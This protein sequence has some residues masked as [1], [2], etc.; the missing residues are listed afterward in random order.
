MIGAFVFVHAGA[1]PFFERGDYELVLVL[2]AAALLLAVL[3]AGRYSL[4]HQ[5]TG[6]RRTAQPVGA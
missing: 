4:D 6:R 3:G 1:G 5:L 2:G